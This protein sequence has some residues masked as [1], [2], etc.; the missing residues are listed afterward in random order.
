MKRIGIF[1]FHDKEGIVD[2]Y[3]EFLLHELCRCLSSLVIVINGKINDDGKLI[4]EKYADAI[5]IRENKGFDGGAYKDVILNILG[6]KK[7][8]EF[9]ELVLCNDTFYGPFISFESIFDEMENRHVDFWGM[10]YYHNI[11]TNHILSYFLVFNKKVINEKIIIEYFNKNINL[12]TQNINDVYGEFEAGLFYYMVKNGYSFSTYSENNPFDINKCSNLCIKESKVPILKK[13]AFS[14]KYFVR[15]NIMDALKYLRQNSNFD[16]DL[17]LDNVK[18]L[19]NLTITKQEIEEFNVDKEDIIRI[20]Y[21]VARINDKDI[22]RIVLMGKK[23]YVYGLG[24]F[25][26]IISQIIDICHGKIAGYIVSDNQND[27]P[28]SKNGIK[29]YKVSEIDYIDNMVIIVALNKEHTEEVRPYLKKF[30]E[31]ICLW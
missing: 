16:L 29:V 21:D 6:W 14:P 7:I 28:E 3:I 9:D 5:Y 23:I 4:L 22:K 15:N 27:I 19:Y 30:K 1:C 13:K 8:Q 31:V 10:S 2:K 11:I 24:V 26:G 20:K 25:S 18:R 12:S 17:I